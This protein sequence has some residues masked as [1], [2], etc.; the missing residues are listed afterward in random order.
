VSFYGTQCMLMNAGKRLIGN[1]FRLKETFS[2]PLMTC[3]L[4]WY[5]RK[6]RQTERADDGWAERRFFRSHPGVSAISWILSAVSP[7]FCLTNKVFIAAK[8]KSSREIVLMRSVC[9]S[10]S[11]LQSVPI[12]TITWIFGRNLCECRPIFDILL[13][14]YSQI[15]S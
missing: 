12:K 14:T 15:F 5:C 10:V 3:K 8:V 2:T 13:M 7:T 1:D 11:R 4:R 6:P 9:L